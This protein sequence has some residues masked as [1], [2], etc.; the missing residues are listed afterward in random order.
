MSTKPGEFQ[1]SALVSANPVEVDVV[2]TTAAGVPVVKTVLASSGG[3]SFG[4][5]AKVLA[6]T[7][8]G[9]AATSA[10]G[11]VGIVS[12]PDASL[13][14]LWSAGPVILK[15]RTQVHGSVHAPSISLINGA[16]VNGTQDLAPKLAPANKLSWHVSYPAQTVG[17]VDVE[18]GLLQTIAPGRYD[19]VRVASRATLKL[20]SGSYYLSTLQLEPQAIVSLDQDKGPVIIYATQSVQLRGSF[21]PVVGTTPDVAVV[22]LGTS[23]V[24]LET[25]FSGTLIAPNANITLRSV[26]PAHEG[27]FFG[28]SLFVDPGAQVKY[29]PPLAIL[30]AAAGTDLSTCAS[31]VPPR[32]DLTGTAREVALQQDIARFCSMQGASLCS[33]QIAARTNVDEATIG[34]ALSAEVI[35]PAKF[36]AVIRDRIRKER[37]ADE[38]PVL[39]QLMCNTPDQDG[40]LVPDSRD[41]CP[42]TPPLTATFDNGCP[43]PSVPLAPSPQDVSTVFTHS[44]ILLDPRCS[45]AFPLPDEVAGGFYYPSD[46]SR[47]DYIVAG[48]VVNQP[49]GCPVWYVFDIE[50][51]PPT[52]PVVSYQAAFADTEEVTSLVGLGTPVPSGFIQFNPRPTELGTRGMLANVG[53]TGAVRFRVRSM[54]G[55]GMHSVWSNWKHTTNADCTALGFQCAN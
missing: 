26:S 43:D 4:G 25:P 20:S 46:R 49:V 47:G 39:A 14:D 2:L 35:T 23:T 54:N 45:G 21:P 5:G 24:Y 36:L 27:F 3:I 44:G 33:A 37:A 55:G 8:T 32:S 18:P 16:A 15:D 7:F 19:T 28:N 31:L 11:A 29:R 53:G 40:D 48:R 42:N 30:G 34:L 50:V 52:G 13:Q 41:A 17:A 10:L 1:S 12:E 51:T 22:Y 9:G 38:D 6:S